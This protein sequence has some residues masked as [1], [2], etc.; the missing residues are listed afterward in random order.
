M[1]AISHI[2][3]I[4]LTKNPS[5]IRHATAKLSTHL[6]TGSPDLRK[7]NPHTDGKAHMT[8]I[9]TERPELAFHHRTAACAPAKAYAEPAR[10]KDRASARAKR[11]T[12]RHGAPKRA[13]S[14]STWAYTEPARKP[15][16]RPAQ[17]PRAQICPPSMRIRPT[18]TWI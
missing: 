11:R 12:M 3:M 9:G 16:P 6:C 17:P 4:S 5:A 15:P 13:A 7:G 1:V 10:N 8:C 2:T 14:A 18:L